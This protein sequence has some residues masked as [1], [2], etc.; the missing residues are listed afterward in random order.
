MPLSTWGNCTWVCRSVLAFAVKEPREGVARSP[1]SLKHLQGL[2][3]TLA[4]SGFYLV[5][6]LAHCVPIITMFGFTP[7]KAIAL[8][9][10]PAELTTIVIA[11]MV[12]HAITSLSADACS[13]RVMELGTSFDRIRSQRRF[14]HCDRLFP[15]L[16]WLAATEALNGLAHRPLFTSAPDWLYSPLNLPSA[17]PLWAFIKPSYLSVCLLARF[18]LDLL[19]KAFLAAIMASGLAV[20][21]RLLW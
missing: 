6:L 7:L 9:A 16:Y 21:S 17:L 18:W 2:S 10:S 5:H 8:G 20:S 13:H 3:D 12:P 11:F 15:S 4:D 1:I 19:M 14:Y